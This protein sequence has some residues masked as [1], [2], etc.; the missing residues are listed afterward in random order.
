MIEPAEEPV[1]VLAFVSFYKRCLRWVTPTHL[2]ST[3]K[4]CV[5]IDFEQI[6]LS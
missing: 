4:S 6:P 5:A 1:S 3:F 2:P